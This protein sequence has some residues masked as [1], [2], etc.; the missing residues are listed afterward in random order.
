MIKISFGYGCFGWP[1]SE[2]EHCLNS[3]EAGLILVLWSSRL[4]KFGRGLRIKVKDT[5]QGHRINI[6]SCSKFS[7]ELLRYLIEWSYQI[8]WRF[9]GI[10]TWAFWSPAMK[11]NCYLLHITMVKLNSCL[12]LSQI[13][14]LHFTKIIISRNINLLNF[15]GI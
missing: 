11:L 14:C 4:L 1:E 9:I 3:L 6:I 10:L 8:G 7:S 2:S 12:L 5:T 15:N 13:P